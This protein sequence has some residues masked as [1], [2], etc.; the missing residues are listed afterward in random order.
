[1]VCK[2]TVQKEESNSLLV[3]LYKGTK[4]LLLFREALSDVINVKMDQLIILFDGHN[5]NNQ[6]MFIAID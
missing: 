6:Q 1:M 2:K 3:F 4:F 5:Q